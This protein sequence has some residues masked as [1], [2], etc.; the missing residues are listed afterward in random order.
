MNLIKPTKNEIPDQFETERLLVRRHRAADVDAL[1]EAARESIADVGPFLSWCH[2]DYLVSES[3]QWI[4]QTISN[5]GDNN[6][7]SFAIEE[8]ASQRFLGG[9]GINGI[10]SH[11]MVNLGYWLR[12]SEMGKGY[13]IEATKGLINWTFEVL[14][15][16]RIEIILSIENES[17]KRVA[18]KTGARFEGTLA[19]RL[20]LHGRQHDAYLFA[21]TRDDHSNSHTAN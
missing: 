18:E 6:L 1:Y 3:K 5:W 13:A 15:I 12:S 17:S 7:F 2:P 11:P 20:Q 9:I 10:D 16:H 8:K 4:D 19:S 21:L 14:K